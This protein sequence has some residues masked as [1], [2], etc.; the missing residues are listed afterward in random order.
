MLKLFAVLGCIYF[1]SCFS[2]H[3]KHYGEKPIIKIQD[4]IYLPSFFEGAEICFNE[5]LGLLLLW[6][7][8]DDELVISDRKGEI[9]GLIQDRDTLKH[10]RFI[11]GNF[12]SVDSIFILY[13]EIG[14][15]L[16]SLKSNG[17]SLIE[18]HLFKEIIPLNYFFTHPLRIYPYKS[19]FLTI[20]HNLFN[21]HKL[22]TFSI[23]LEIDKSGKF[24]SWLVV[25]S[26]NVNLISSPI[27]KYMK[28]YVDKDEIIYLFN[29]KSLNL[30]KVENDSI[31][32]VIEIGKHI[33]PDYKFDQLSIHN[34]NLAMIR[35]LLEGENQESDYIGKYI[36]LDLE[37]GKHLFE[38]KIFKYSTF[39]YFIDFLEDGC[40]I[41]VD[42][43]LNYNEEPVNKILYVCQIDNEIL[44]DQF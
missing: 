10:G 17:L 36:F 34:I 32:T 6:N 28:L 26:H 42:N 40:L 16:F 41:A 38:Y 3:D 20:N 15:S 33:L 29:E 44:Q 2:N 43:L 37:N 7:Y 11:S 8:L 23:L 35:I 12:S 14:I 21:Y 39:Q 4:T 13:T 22:N 27:E 1:I 24:E 30:L 9:L 18:S 31:S 25:D 19:K 5:K